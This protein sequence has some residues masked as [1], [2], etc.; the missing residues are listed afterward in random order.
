MQW[1]IVSSYKI[2]LV[3]VSV[4]SGLAQN[5][6]FRR[7]LQ[8]KHYL[9]L[10]WFHLKCTDLSTTLFWLELVKSKYSFNLT[11]AF[12]LLLTFQGA[13]WDKLN[14]NKPLLWWDIPY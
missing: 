9:V 13:Q 3:Y 1:V 2:K 6:N 5:T 12:L 11:K 14:I 8:Y 4:N 10:T 7:P